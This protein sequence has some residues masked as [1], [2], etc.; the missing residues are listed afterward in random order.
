MSYEFCKLVHQNEMNIENTHDLM[1]HG[2][3]PVAFLKLLKPLNK[4]R[5]IG[6]ENEI[7]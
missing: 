5:R 7:I 1:G 4:T 6:K 2:A 3:R